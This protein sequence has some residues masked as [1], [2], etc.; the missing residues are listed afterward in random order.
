MSGRQREETE[1]WM[2]SVVRGGGRD[3]S[4]GGTVYYLQYRV[5]LSPSPAPRASGSR[6]PCSETQRAERTRVREQIMFK[7]SAVTYW[8]KLR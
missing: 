1:L 3:R 2:S 5:H 6:C 8:S 7:P 4:V